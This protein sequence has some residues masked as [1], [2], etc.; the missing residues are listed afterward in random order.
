MTALYVIVKYLTVPGAF[1]KAFFE[2][3]VC[4]VFE[5]LVED[6][7]YLAR[8]EMCGH[9]EHEFIKKRSV[10]A[11]MCFFPFVINLILGLIFISAG[12]MNVLYLGEYFNEN[13]TP[14]FINFILL[15][16]GI[17]MLTNLFPQWEDALTFKELWYSKDTNIVLKILI[18]PLFAIIYCGAFLEKNGITLLTSIAFAFAVP[19]IYRVLLPALYAL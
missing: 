4:R 1:A 15:W 9:I 3:L 11:V 10:C 6:G 14:V 17:S 2:H 8:S 12:S 19:M 16:I 18:A 7:R 13:G 5:V